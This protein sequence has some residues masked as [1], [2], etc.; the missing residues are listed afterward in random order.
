MNGEDFQGDG[1][2]CLI[3][4]AGCIALWAIVIALVAWWLA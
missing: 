3:A 4:I 2:G 1:R